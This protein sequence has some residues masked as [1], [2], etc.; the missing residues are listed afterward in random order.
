MK[1]LS[2]PFMSNAHYSLH[3]ALPFSLHGTYI[4]IQL[5]WYSHSLCKATH[6]TQFALYFHSLSKC[7]FVQFA[8]SKDEHVSTQHELGVQ[9]RWTALKD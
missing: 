1:I 5:A 8:F 4:P 7:G 2:I 3:I 6:P 9:L